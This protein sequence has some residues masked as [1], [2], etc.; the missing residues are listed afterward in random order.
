MNG[1]DNEKFIEAV[2]NANIEL[3]TYI[4]SNLSYSDITYTNT[5]GFGGD[6]S[7][8]IDIIA[9]NIFIRHLSS[10]GDVFSEECGLLS[11]KSNFKIIID[12]I[13]GS[14]NFMHNLPYYGS[15][16]ALKYKDETL[17]SF[18]C[19]LVSGILTYKIENSE[20]RYYDL[21]KQNY[22]K[23][24][25]QNSSKLAIF[26]KSYDNPEICLKL[27]Q[28]KIKYRSAGAM[29]LSLCD[30]RNYRFA[31]FKGQIRDFDV[32]A[33]LYINSDL[34]VHKKDDILILALNKKDFDFVLEIIKDI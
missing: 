10:F 6:N 12:P 33:A 28:N 23:R 27:S 22:I 2:K 1:F 17:A 29:A 7:L 8:K 13:D 25:F 3:M 21:N 16:V 11:N 32:A 4:N 34:Y 5:T 24:F 20:I 18:V 31:M 26:E 30:A 19:N 14:S 15:S 9:E